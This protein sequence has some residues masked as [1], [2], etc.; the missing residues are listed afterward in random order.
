LLCFPSL[1]KHHQEND[2]SIDKLHFKTIILNMREA[3]LSKFQEFK[4]STATF[5]F[6]KSFLSA[7]IT[8]LTFSPLKIDISSFEMQLLD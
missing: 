3:S 7:K 4:N 8:W 2:S 6:V 5:A 1:L